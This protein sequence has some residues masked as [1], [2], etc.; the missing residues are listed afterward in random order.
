MVIFQKPSKYEAIAYIVS[1]SLA[2]GLLLFSWSSAWT[3][4]IAGRI[5]YWIAIL[6]CCGFWLSVLVIIVLSDFLKK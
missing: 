2:L 5:L 4:D 1:L 6:C 3:A